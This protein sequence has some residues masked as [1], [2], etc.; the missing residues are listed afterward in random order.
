MSRK[1]VVVGLIGALAFTALGVIAAPPNPPRRPAEPVPLARAVTLTVREIAEGV[2]ALHEALP[3]I[4]PRLEP[5]VAILKGL[6]EAMEAPAEINPEDV[7]VELI[8][9]SLHLH[10]LLFDLESEARQVAEFRESVREL[11]ARF[12][13]GM[14]PRQAERF[15]R[16]VRGLM[17]LVQERLGERAPGAANP[18]ELGRTIVR[19]KAAVNRLDLLLLRTLEPRAEE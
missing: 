4:G 7:Q 18:E 11:V 9:L 5:I 16:F 19:L 13:E 2:R 15:H 6:G 8:R 3:M 14:E 10:R 17:D 1:M 12:A